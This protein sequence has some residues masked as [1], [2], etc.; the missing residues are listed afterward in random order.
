VHEQKWVS[1]ESTK[2]RARTNDGLTS[3]R[4]MNLERNILVEVASETVQRN[5][6]KQAKPLPKVC[7][8]SY[9]Y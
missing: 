5:I 3:D 2:R 1:Q 7:H 8:T 9:H 4:A 6:Q